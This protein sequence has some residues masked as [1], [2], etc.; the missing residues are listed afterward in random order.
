M[1]H[2]LLSILTFVILPLQA[3]KTLTAADPI[4]KLLRAEQAIKALYVDSLDE[5]KL[6]EDGIRGMLQKLDPHSSYTNAKETK[7]LNEPL[8]GNF[9]GIG[10]SFNMLNDTLLVI[11]PVVKGPSDKVGIMAG[12][13][14]VSVNDTTIAGVK[15]AREEIMRCLRGPK[16]SKVKLGVIRRGIK[17]PL[18]FTVTRDKIPLHTVDASYMLTPSVGYIRIGSFGMTTAQE[19]HEALG[20]LLDQGMKGL[21]LDLQSNGGGYLG[22]S[23]EVANE[24]LEQGDMVVYTKGRAVPNREY[25]AKGDGLFRKGKIAV[26]TNEF[27]ASAAEIVTGALQDHDRATVVGRRSFGKG[28]VQ[29]PI[30]LPDGSMIRLTVSHYYTPAG[31]CIQKPYEKGK[32]ADYDRDWL[33]RL[34]RGELTSA[35]SI[36]LSDT[37]QYRT[38]REKR[39]VYGGGGIVPDHFIPLD[40]T[41]YTRLYRELSTRNLLINASLNYID[42]HRKSL[43]KTYTSFDTFKKQFQIPD[44]VVNQLLAEGEKAGLKAKDQAERQQ[45][46]QHIRLLLKALTARDIWDQSEYFEIINEEDPAIRKA[47]ELIQ[48]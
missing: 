34:Q 12:D 1:K 23:I 2:F 13:R 25:R 46:I 26:L 10:I 16:G 48:S 37:L 47:I 3:Q 36:H 24:F 15:L 27:T 35:D 31:R 8:A 18:V 17:D 11:Q 21:I 42:Q 6:V 30:D 40:T 29:I 4:F 20:K 41:R 44:N 39:V 19:V 28:L 38:L 7:S 22:A 9:E 32:K 43:Q 45:T 5:S 14:I 33:D